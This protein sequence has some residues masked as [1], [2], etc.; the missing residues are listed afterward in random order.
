MDSNFFFILVKY[1]DGVKLIVF[2]YSR[3]QQET[4]FKKFL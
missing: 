3:Q 4:L 2:F 1:F